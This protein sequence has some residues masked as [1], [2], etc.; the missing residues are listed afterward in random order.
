MDKSK[1]AAHASEIYD[2][3]SC[4]REPIHQLGGIQAHGYLI[5]VSADWIICF[6]SA[7]AGDILD[8]APETLIG[9]PLADAMGA[10]F[11]H[12]ARNRLQLS[13]ANGVA[14]RLDPIEFKN[15]RVLTPQL[16]YSEPY[17]ILEF[18]PDDRSADANPIETA[19]A[20]VARLQ[21][22]PETKQLLD[23]AARYLKALT[24]FDRVMVYRFLPDG[25]GEVISEARQREMEPYL[26]LRYPASDIPQQA[27]ALYLRNPI[28]CIAD[29]HAAPTPLLPD[30]GPRGERLDLSHSALR[31]VSAI[32][33]EYLRNMGVGASMSVSIIQNG[34]LW[35]LF[36]C[37]HLTPKRVP[38]ATRIAAD[39][40]GQMFSL[41][42]QDRERRDA[43]EDEERVATLHRAILSSIADHGSELSQ[44][45]AL[46]E[47]FSRLIECDGVAICVRDG[48][49][50]H[51]STPTREE[52]GPLLRHL[53]STG[54]AD[55]FASNALSRHFPPARDFT[56][57]AAGLLAIPISRRPRDY[58]I[59]FRRETTQKIR[60]AGDP[61]KPVEPGPN[62]LRLTPRKSFEAYQE[63]VREQSAP[64]SPQSIRIATGL[65]TTLLEVVLKLNDVVAT[66]RRQNI[67][68]QELLISELNHRV[69]NLLGLVRGIVNQT[70]GQY[71]NSAEFVDV[72]DQRIKALARAHDQITEQ[73][74]SPGSV[75]TLLERE[76]SAY[77]HEGM[78]RVRLSGPDVRLT[79]P[80]F[81]TLALVVHELMTN[82]AKYG[83]LS[84]RSGHIECVFAIDALGQFRFDWRDVGGPPVQP[85]TRRGFGST[86]IERSIPYDLDGEADIRYPLQGAE[87]S[88]VIPARYVAE[89][90]EPAPAD[91]PDATPAP[92]P[93]EESDLRLIAE[94]VLLVED[95]MIIAL[96]LE[97]VLYELGAEQVIVCAT[98]EDAL[99]AISAEAPTFALLDVNL[100]SSTS[101]PIAE[102]LLDLSAPFV[103][104]T[105]YGDDSAFPDRFAGV[106]RLAK[107]VDTAT[108]K[109][110]LQAAAANR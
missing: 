12:A 40:F 75:R 64:W 51:G 98:V 30:I 100:S 78:R 27:R 86:I 2:L 61:A 59:F 102:R 54:A 26:G 35:G 87:A 58:L 57:R 93:A 20:T 76:A 66:E 90:E 7:N 24:G 83:A 67:E 37:H 52:M 28:R 77:L 70:K 49:V 72:L 18:E 55:I 105:G 56:E 8:A 101:F 19:R 38:I 79:P 82:S 88:F 84:D 74:W 53:N 99:R 13:Y 69:R 16:H 42:L 110:A 60:W 1:P 73:N 31:S 96:D 50:L 43:L 11:V 103:F 62:G 21:S 14:E 44:L 81:A 22:I 47:D 3:T 17:Y 108:I 6:A 46:I 71:A 65:R 15:G 4:D 48:I 10:K 32:H 45:E 85:P 25:A 36:A 109:A 97:D 89:L 95:N 29:A 39:L 80:A 23:R 106:P 41:M 92:A 91:I 68:K 9:T 34:A 104:A 107:P 5:A 33:L 94:R 63:T